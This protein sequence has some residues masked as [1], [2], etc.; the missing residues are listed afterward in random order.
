MNTQRQK[1]SVAILWAATLLVAGVFLPRLFC[2]EILPPAPQLLSRAPHTGYLLGPGDQINVHVVDLEEYSDKTMRIDPDGELDLPLIGSLHAGGESIDA[3]KLELRSR[4]SRYV[5]SP[6]ISVTLLNSRSSK[7]SVVGELNSPGVRELSGPTTLIE[8]ISEAGGLKADAGSRVVVTRSLEAGRLP[9]D[10]QV[11]DSSG[12]YS[13]VSL[14]LDDL[15]ISKRPADN[16]LLRP[17]DIVS[18]PKASIVYVVGDVH[19]AGGFPIS[20]HSSMSVL[21]AISLAEGLGPN[22]SS[23]NARILRPAPG[24][25]GKPT[26]IPVNVQA[27][28]AGKAPDPPLFAEDILYIP[29]SSAKAGAKRAAEISL[30]VAT[31]VLIYR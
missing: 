1:H 27:I 31:G 25:D 14:P 7:V 20:S 24:G 9:V 17:G 2:Q 10:G 30:Q 13:T 5:N 16:F 4:L 23:R 22:D 3:F 26:E 29:N 21:Q 6:Q 18:V 15:M 12:L 8:A 28:F 11:L 19:R